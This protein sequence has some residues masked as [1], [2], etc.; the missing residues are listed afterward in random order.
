MLDVDDTEDVL[1]LEDSEQFDPE[2]QIQPLERNRY[3]HLLHSSYP[4][5]PVNQVHRKDYQLP[6]YSML[7]NNNTVYVRSRNVRFST[8]AADGGSLFAKRII[9]V[10]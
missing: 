10:Q 9:R 4:Y 1:L 7:K 5:Y 8:I 3:D 6:P 2:K